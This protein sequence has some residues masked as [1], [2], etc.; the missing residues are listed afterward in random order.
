MSEYYQWMFENSVPGLPEAAA[1]EGISALEYMRKYGAFLVAENI[2][3][4]HATELKET[5]VAE[6]AVDPVTKVVSKGGAAI[7]VE[8]DGKAHAGFP[9]PSE[10][11]SSIPRP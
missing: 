5:D 3:S 9:T 7:G 1:E 8:V 6:A 2:Y 11:S 10:S 4:S